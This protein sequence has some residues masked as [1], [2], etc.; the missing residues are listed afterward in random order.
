[1]NKQKPN[2]PLSE[3]AIAPASALAALFIGYAVQISNGH[4]HN[5]SIAWVSAAIL[6]L[7]IGV[8]WHPPGAWRLGKQDLVLAI[9]VVGAAF[10]FT[11]LYTAQPVIYLSGGQSLSPFFGAVALAAMLTG[12]GLSKHTLVERWQ[13]WL[14]VAVFCYAGQWVLKLSPDPAI[15]VFVF[16]RDALAALLTGNNPYELTFPNI[17]GNNANYGPGI[18]EGGRLQF[19]YPYLPL[20]LLLV[21]PGEILGDFRYAQLIALAITALM[22]AR[23]A[24]GPVGRTLAAVYLF[25]P[26]IFFILEQSWTEPLLVFTAT[27]VLWIAW[28][29]PHWLPYAVGLLFVTKQF[30][31]I[32]VPIVYLLIRYQ[33][34]ELKQ[35][36][37][38]VLKVVVTGAIVTLPFALWGFDG[39]WKSV[40]MLQFHLPFRPDSLSYLAFFATEGQ[41]PITHYFAFLIAGFGSLLA[42]WRVPRNPAGFFVSAA[43]I[44]ILFFAFNK[45]AFCNYYFLVLGLS[46]VAVAACFP[47]DP[48][49]EKRKGALT[50]GGVG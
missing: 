4:L 32:V 11:R 5:Q 14:L 38:W 29:R 44:F 34:I 20:S 37:P 35:A 2:S 6:V 27:L 50:G 1:M 15:D 12:L 17:Y 16:Q 46:C 25:T 30:L 10:Q 3:S 7:L 19:G 36:G 13:P 23:L 9:L 47:G 22:F 49:M 28:R 43:L 41:P 18:V 40:V 8:V 26:R 48:V 21:L 42:F 31:V 33:S 24:P 45:Q 39:F